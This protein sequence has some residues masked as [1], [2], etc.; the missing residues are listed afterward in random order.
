LNSGGWLLLEH[1]NTQAGAVAQLLA[2]HG[3]ERVRS[4][5]DYSSEPRVT[6]GRASAPSFS[7]SN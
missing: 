7:S 4:C 6:L 5:N 3:F 2:R 1:G